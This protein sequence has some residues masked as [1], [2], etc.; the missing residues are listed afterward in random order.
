MEGAC[1]EQPNGI[2]RFSKQVISLVYF[3]IKLQRTYLSYLM[4]A[5]NTQKVWCYIISFFFADGFDCKLPS[6]GENIVHLK[7]ILTSMYV[8]H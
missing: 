2:H 5:S 8:C 3:C 7:I 1:Q 6:S 4:Y